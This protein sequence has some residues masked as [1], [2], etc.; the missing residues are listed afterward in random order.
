MDPKKGTIHQNSVINARIAT[1]LTE[2]E[3]KH[4]LSAEQFISKLNDTQKEELKVCT[5]SLSLFEALDI[6]NS[7]NAFN[8]MCVKPQPAKRGTRYLAIL[9][10]NKNLTAIDVATN[11]VTHIGT[12]ERVT[13]KPKRTLFFKLTTEKKPREFSVKHQLES[14][15][16]CLEGIVKPNKTNIHPLIVLLQ[17]FIELPEEVPSTFPEHFDYI[18]KESFTKL[19]LSANTSI[20]N[21][22]QDIALPSAGTRNIGDLIAYLGINHHQLFFIVNAL[23]PICFDKIKSPSLILR[24]ESIVTRVINTTRNHYCS[25]YYSDLIQKLEA[26]VTSLNSSEEFLPAAIEVLRQNPPPAILRLLMLS[27]NNAAKERFPEEPNAGNFAMSNVY[28]LRGLGP[29][30]TPKNPDLQLKYSLITMLFNFTNNPNVVPFTPYL[31]DYLSSLIQDINY[32]EIQN[33]QPIPDKEIDSLLKETFIFFLT[34]RTQFKEYLEKPFTYSKH[35]VQIFLE[36]C[37]RLL[38]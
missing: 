37:V 19:I 12:V 18:I 29:K 11:L 13:S 33:L 9:Q 20:L 5:D 34:Q 10:E 27:A 35:A 17:P 2:D 25:E 16:D 3:I 32:E 26:A 23:L 7:I 36:Q 1:W 4:A 30:L 38:Q 14:L 8:F 28:L 24:G 22:L 15:Q 31:R 6:N 21:A